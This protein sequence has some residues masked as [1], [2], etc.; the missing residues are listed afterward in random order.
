MTVAVFSLQKFR[1]RYKETPDSMAPL[2][3][4]A[5]MILAEALSRAGTA[6]GPKLRDALAAPLEEEASRRPRREEVERRTALARRGAHRHAGQRS[7]LV[8]GCRCGKERRAGRVETAGPQV[9]ERW[10]GA[11]LQRGNR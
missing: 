5:V 4:D 9:A 3:Y 6:D 1:A 10:Q 8:A 7:K 2:A 11:G